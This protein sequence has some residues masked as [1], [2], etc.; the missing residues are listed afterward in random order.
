M[1]FLFGAFSFY[2]LHDFVHARR[3]SARFDYIELFYKMKMNEK[4]L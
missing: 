4:T 3:L 2:A 1:A